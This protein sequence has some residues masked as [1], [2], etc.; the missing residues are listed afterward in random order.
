MARSNKDT[1]TKRPRSGARAKANPPAPGGR[2]APLDI[3]GKFRGWT[4]AV[5][6]MAGPVA[7]LS[8]ALAEARARRRPQ[9]AAIEKAGALLRTMREAVGMSAEEAGRA[10]GLRD[11][12]LLEQA[13]GGKVA[14]PFDAILRLAGVLAKKDPMGFAMKLMRAYQ[15]DVW[16]TLEQLR[17]GGLVM[18]GTRERAVLDIYRGNKAAHELSNEEFADVLAFTKT[19]FNMVV[20][21]RAGPGDE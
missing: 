10:A 15:P 5:L 20:D 1:D 19:V 9:T 11:A 14:L 12:S 6:G 3:A 7:N 2:P 18:P 21:F 17:V 8:Q 4:D 16:K 13:E